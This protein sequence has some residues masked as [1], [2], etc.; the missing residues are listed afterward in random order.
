MRIEL[1]RIEFFGRTKCVFNWKSSIISLGEL[2]VLKYG[3][4]SI[5]AFALINGFFPFVVR[6][7]RYFLLPSHDIFK[8]KVFNVH[9]III[10]IPRIEIIGRTKTK[11]IIVLIGGWPSSTIL[12]VVQRVLTT[13]FYTLGELC[14]L[15][16]TQSTEEVRFLEEPT[17]SVRLSVG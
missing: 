13:I 5:S 6:K 4:K 15:G 7:P 10:W 1:T 11:S 17:R 14:K 8:L 12:R 3:T 16:L 9:V 2:K